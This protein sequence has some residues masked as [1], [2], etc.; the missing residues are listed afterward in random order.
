MSGWLLGI[1][2]VLIG[3]G[4]IALLFVTESRED[5]DARRF[6]AEEDRRVHAWHAEQAR[7]QPTQP[8]AD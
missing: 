7:R 4:A 6:D 8:G 5:R 2:G 1:G 3:F